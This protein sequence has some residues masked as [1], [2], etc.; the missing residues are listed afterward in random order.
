M[1]PVPYIVLA[2]LILWKEFALWHYHRVMPPIVKA[3]IVIPGVALAVSYV[4]FQFY[5]QDLPLEFRAMMARDILFVFFLW[6]GL[7]VFFTRDQH[8]SLP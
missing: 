1:Q 7:L 5:E 2:L 8:K 6:N 4:I 3:A